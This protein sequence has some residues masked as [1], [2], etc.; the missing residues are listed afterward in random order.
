MAGGLNDRNVG[1]LARRLPAPMEIDVNSGVKSAPGIKSRPKLLTFFETLR[2]RE[3]A[4][5]PTQTIQ[6]QTNPQL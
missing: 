6:P 1:E 2:R 4:D 5:G 3:R